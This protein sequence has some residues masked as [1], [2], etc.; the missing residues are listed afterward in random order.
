MVRVDQIEVVAGHGWDPRVLV[1]RLAPIVDCF[2]VVSDRY[3]LLIDTMINPRTG[4]AL[5]DIARGHLGGGRSLLV[6]NTH[7]D[8]DHCWGNQVFAGPHP[9]HPA[10]VIASRLCAEQFG[11]PAAAAYLAGEQARAPERY[12]DVVYAPATVRFDQRLTIDGGGLTV[13]LFETPGHAPGHISAWIPEIRTL[14]AGD[15]AESPFP[16]ARTAAMLPDLRASLARMAALDPAVALYRHAP[17]TLGPNLL[18]DNIAYFDALEARCRAALA[19]GLRPKPEQGTPLEE[20]IGFPFT[21]AIPAGID[22]ATVHE[23]Y[24]TEGHRT[25]IRLMLAWLTTGDRSVRQTAPDRPA[26]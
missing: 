11:T 23:F 20:Q 24:R 16:F 7:A 9:L 3:V 26:R 14:I 22:P 4:A 13:E 6:V 17:V 25:Q 5:L 15:A 21:E 19:R 18:R 2:I 8:Y 1:R 12:A 10:P